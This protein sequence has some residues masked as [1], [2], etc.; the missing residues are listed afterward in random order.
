[1][2]EW[3]SGFRIVLLV[4]AALIET[5]FAHANS[6]ILD[7]KVEALRQNMSLVVRRFRRTSALV[8]EWSQ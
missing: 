6:Y 3:K 1:M 4:I 8:T 7:V 5:G 2:L